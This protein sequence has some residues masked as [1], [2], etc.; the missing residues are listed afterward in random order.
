MTVRALEAGLITA[1]GERLACFYVDALGFT[2][3]R[4]LEFPQGTVRRLSHGTALLK[5]FE[6]ADAPMPLAD[7]PWNAGSG[8][9]YAALHVV[10]A[11]SAVAA[12]TAHGGTIVADVSTHRPGACFALVTDPD[13]NVW[14]I[15]QEN[16]T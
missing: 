14:E 15:R 6:P 16:P 5:I 3:D 13:G 1:D 10:D 11:V 12:I 8:F 4:T 2:V 7:Q 9:R